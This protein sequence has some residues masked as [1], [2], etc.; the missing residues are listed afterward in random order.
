[1]DKEKGP[2]LNDDECVS[3]LELKEM[4]RVMIEAF[5][6]NTRTLR[7]H[8]MSSLIDELLNLLHAWMYW[9]LVPPPPTPAPAH[10][11]V[12]DDDDGDVY[13]PL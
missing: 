2:K 8:P 9:R 4:M 7:R 5:K 6:K 11:P 12:H 3:H 13:A 1:M 10:S